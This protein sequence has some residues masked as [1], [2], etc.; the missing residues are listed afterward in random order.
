MAGAKGILHASKKNG[1]KSLE[2]WRRP[3]NQA[4]AMP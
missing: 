1:A 4:T 3:V 2:T